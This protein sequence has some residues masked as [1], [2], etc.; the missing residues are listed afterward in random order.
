[1]SKTCKIKEYKVIKDVLFFKEIDN[2]IKKKIIDN[3]EFKSF[4]SFI[5]NIIINPHT[6]NR[7][8]YITINEL[9][10]PN[11]KDIENFFEHLK[12]T[13]FAPL[14]NTKSLPKKE[15]G[16]CYNTIK[17]PIITHN[18]LTCLNASILKMLE[19][20]NSCEFM[21]ADV[22]AALDKMYSNLKV[23]KPDSD[24][25]LE[26]IYLLDNGKETNIDHNKLYFLSQIV[27]ITVM[28]LNELFNKNNI[29]KIDLVL[30]ATN[31]KKLFPNDG[32]VKNII[33]DENNANSGDTIPKSFDLYRPMIRLYRTEELIKVLIHEVIHC[34]GFETQ[35]GDS[36]QHNFKV[37]NVKYD[38]SDLLFNETITETLAE[39]INCVLYSLIHNKQLND[40]LNEE[41]DF[42]FMQTVKILDYYNFISLNDFFDTNTNKLIKQK[43]AIFEYH[44]LK[45]VLL[46]R[47]NDFIVLLHTGTANDLMSLIMKTMTSD[48]GYKKYISDHF[49]KLNSLSPELKGTFR[50]TKLE[51]YTIDDIPLNPIMSGGNM[52]FHNEYNKYKS[53]YFIL[54]NQNV[55]R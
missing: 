42:G 32:K 35:F 40:I 47:F 22:F 20:F 45:T 31:A 23:Y 53:R 27:N 19:Y 13:S 10:S 26:N 30:Y 28:S 38:N 15:Y 24:S 25:N 12:L 44:I 34:T 1:M 49:K 4:Q 33:L 2:V 8:K 9:N 46:Y 52:K 5:N 43:T 16:T 17:S 37:F 50:M 11:K 55:I 29:V 6:Y 41:I 54:R 39:F 21:S 51:I 18:D 14:Q 36:P 48:E 3:A 7:L